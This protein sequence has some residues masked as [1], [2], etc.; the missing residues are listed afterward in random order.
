MGTVVT[1]PAALPVAL[2]FFQMGV[3]SEPS[4][5]VFK[6]P[7]FT[8]FPPPQDELA[9]AES[10][11]RELSEA[12]S[13]I[14][15][16]PLLCSYNDNH[17]LWRPSLR[18]NSKLAMVKVPMLMPSLTRKIMFLAILPRFLTSAS[19]TAAITLPGDKIAA[20]N[21]AAEPPLKKSL[22]FILQKTT[23]DVNWR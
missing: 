8:L 3:F 2:N 16:L 20:P 23:T 18:C 15:R 1:H 12:V 11:T 14:A 13:I 7:L 9:A 21:K 10:V 19:A 6:A 17:L 4:G 5:F 22:L